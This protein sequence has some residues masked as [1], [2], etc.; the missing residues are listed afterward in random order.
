MKIRIKP[1]EKVRLEIPVRQFKS[2]IKKTLNIKKAIFRL[3][4]VT[5]NH[6]EYTAQKLKLMLFCNENWAY[7]LEMMS[8]T[9]DFDNKN[10]IFRFFPIK[11]KDKVHYENYGRSKNFEKV[12]LT[13]KK[14][15]GEDMILINNIIADMQYSIDQWISK[16][17]WLDNIEWKE[18]IL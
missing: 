9:D 16:S 14:G 11:Y 8:E 5:V 2:E 10:M 18:L 7:I 15:G 6:T 4:Q 17:T 1:E 3:A 12:E 13:E